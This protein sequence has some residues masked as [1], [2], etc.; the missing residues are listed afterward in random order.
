MKVL[1]IL[2]I[3]ISFLQSGVGSFNHY[4]LA[5]VWPAGFCQTQTCIKQVN[6]FIIHG[7]WPQGVDPSPCPKTELNLYRSVVKKL[8]VDWQ[9]LTEKEDKVF[10]KEEWDKH[11]SC[12]MLEQNEYFTAASTIYRKKSIIKI[13]N[14]KGI[15]N[16]FVAESLSKQ[17]FEKAIEDG[18]G[19]KAQLYCD[20]QHNL[21]EVRL[22]MNK[23]EPYDYRDCSAA[24][25]TCPETMV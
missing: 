20:T 13:L 22:C 12:S 1:M 10:W 14:A 25:A 9:S 15:G 8:E 24:S 23:N 5:E 21:V 18:F 16:T 3:L 11:G 6:K 4:M 17:K 2:V 19:V 7:L